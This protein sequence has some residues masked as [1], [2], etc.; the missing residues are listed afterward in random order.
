MPTYAPLAPQPGPS[1]AA[2]YGSDYGSLDR[3]SMSENEVTSPVK[4]MEVSHL[5]MRFAIVN[6][7]CYA[8]LSGL[9]LSCL[10]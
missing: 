4:S 2:S 1:Q 5:S 6:I 10:A 7:T 9:I 8:E 3:S